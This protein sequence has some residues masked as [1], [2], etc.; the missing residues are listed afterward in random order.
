MMETRAHGIKKIK[1][2]NRVTQLLTKV[3][4][5]GIEHSDHR[6]DKT[7]YSIENTS[8]EAKHKTI[9]IAIKRILWRGVND[10]SSVNGKQE[11]IQSS[12]S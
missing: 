5:H 6:T 10:D 11:Y 4:T 7:I 3:G 1:E 12:F 9:K 8:P 2:V